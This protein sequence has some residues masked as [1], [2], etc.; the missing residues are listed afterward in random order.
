MKKIW[1]IAWTEYL[2]SVRSKAFIIGVLAMPLMMGGAILVQQFAKD[3]VD[4]KDRN[5]VVIDHSNRLFSV[6]RKTAEQR[7][8]NEIF[9]KENSSK[10]VRPKFIPVLEEESISKPED[11]EKLKLGLSDRVRDKELFAFLVIDKEVFE[12][13][14]TSDNRIAYHTQTPT[15]Q[16]LPRWLE[17]TINHE[18]RRVRFTHE[19]LDQELVSKLIQSSRVEKLGLLEAGEDGKIEKAEKE[20]PIQT[21]GIPAGSMLLLFMMV[22][23][24]APALLNGVLEE[25]MQKIAEFLISSVTPFQLMMGKLMGALM[26]SLTLSMLYL[27]AMGYTAARFEVLDLIPISL[28]FW[29][30]F[31]L[32][33]AMMIFGSIFLAIGSAC[34]EI[35]DAQSLMFPAMLLVMIPV[36]TWAPILESPSSS[37]ARAVSLFPPATP[38][39]LLL[40]MAIPPGLPW[41]EIALG[42]FLSFSFMLVSVWAGAKIFRIGILSQGQAPTFGKMIKWI[43]SK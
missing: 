15:F 36:F 19:N 4:L 32:V 28:F 2:N 41:W 14:S 1:T 6:I 38:M 21:F 24:S 11:E 35:K 17:R 22:M 42:I 31:F 13:D 39:L 16:E 34:S 3:K 30:L 23:S 20:N 9:D 26:V 7:N 37:F 40:R 43:I 33:M 29:F 18:I 8:E 5:F 10:Q 27:A 25:K 12:A